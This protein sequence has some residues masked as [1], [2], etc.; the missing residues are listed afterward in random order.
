M[1]SLHT[2]YK[3]LCFVYYV[4]YLYR[5]YNGLAECLNIV[6]PK[7]PTSSAFVCTNDGVHKRLIHF[8]LNQCHFKQSRPI[9]S[10]HLSEN[11]SQANPFEFIFHFT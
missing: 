5:G 9:S 1:L 3:T 10:F 11:G 2:F 6:L 8:V 4:P 7:T